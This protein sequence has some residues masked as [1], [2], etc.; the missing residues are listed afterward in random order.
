MVVFMQNNNHTTFLSN[1][2]PF[3]E[4]CGIVAL[5]SSKFSIQLPL[6][7]KAAGG[8]QHRGQQGAG[9]VLETK[10][11]F[12]KHTGNGLLREV[13]L[14]EVVSRLNAPSIWTIVH[15]RYG[16]YGGYDKDNLQPCVATDSSGSQIAVAHNGEFVATEKMRKLVINNLPKEISDTNLFTQILSRTKGISWEEKILKTLAEVKGAYSLAIGTNDTLFLARDRFGIRP[17]ILGQARGMWIVTSETQALN[18]IGA[19][20][21]REVQAG[22]V[23]KINEKGLRTIQTGKNQ[24]HFCDFEWAYF[25]RPDS[26]LCRHEKKEDDKTP[27]LWFSASS[28][29][30]KCGTILASESPVQNVSF[31]C[32]V[33]DSG[34]YLATGYANALKIPYRQ[35]IIRDHYDPNGSQRLFMRDD[36][37][38]KIGSKVLGKLSIITDKQI[39][40]DAVVVIG[41]DSIV[42]GNVSKAITKTVFSL[43]AKEVHWII[44]F[45]QVRYRCH[46]GVSMRTEEEL[47]ASRQQGDTAKIAQEIGATSVRYLSLSGFIR[48]RLLSGKLKIPKNKKEIFLANGG[49]GGCV[50]GIYPVTREGKLYD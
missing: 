37:K 34:I 19:K 7:L 39:W 20:V 25:A 43:G 11:G 31:C 26:L 48:T 30:E 17:L 41:D 46:L 13:F 36:Q 24:Y 5:Y 3:Q 28:F 12:V 32:G 4:K 40:K 29:R 23:I 47:V 33:P 15:C 18:R 1:N 38:N 21:I 27:K 44:G 50:T 10:E 42:R 49:C 8:V 14:P 16:T 6:A 2:K 35:V 22:E 45:P 9:V